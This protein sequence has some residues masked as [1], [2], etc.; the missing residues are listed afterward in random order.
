MKHFAISIEVNGIMT[1]LKL[2]L[3]YKGEADRYAI[4]LRELSDSPIFVVNTKSE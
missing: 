4:R 1:Q 2:P 3:M